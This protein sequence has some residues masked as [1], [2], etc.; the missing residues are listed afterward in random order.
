M[1]SPLPRIQLFYKNP[2][3]EK[4]NSL[5]TKKIYILDPK[6]PGD[7]TDEKRIAFETKRKNKPAL[8]DPKS[9]GDSTGEK[10]RE[11]GHRKKRLL[12]PKSPG[13]SNGVSNSMSISIY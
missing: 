3:G 6:S 12:D 4:T 8:L 13:D 11:I 2:R 1:A 10:K 5:A 9:L 7:S